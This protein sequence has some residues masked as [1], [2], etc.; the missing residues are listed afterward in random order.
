VVTVAAPAV[1]AVAPGSGAINYAG[2]V[3]LGDLEPP[4]GSSPQP[5]LSVEGLGPHPPA[6]LLRLHSNRGECNPSAHTPT[7]ARPITAPSPTV[8]GHRPGARQQHHL[9][10]GLWGDCGHG[11]LPARLEHDGGPL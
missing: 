10:P 7:P 4:R 5:T 1:I 9:L 6:A 3:S 2:K 8:H 11:P